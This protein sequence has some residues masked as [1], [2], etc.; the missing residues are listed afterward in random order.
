MAQEKPLQ[1]NWDPEN[2]GPHKELAAAG[3][4]MTHCAKVA[5]GREHRLQRQGNDDIA[6]RTQKGR[7]EE[8]KRLKGPERKKWRKVPRPQAAV[9]RQNQNKGARHKTATAS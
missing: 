3:I 7:T 5:R 8:N 6:P 1:E 9:S 2:C 4:R